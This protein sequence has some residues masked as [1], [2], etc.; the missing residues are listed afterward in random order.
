MVSPQYLYGAAVPTGI[1]AGVVMRHGA[2]YVRLGKRL[3]RV[4]DPAFWE[5]VM[6]SDEHRRRELCSIAAR[7][8]P[9]SAYLNDVEWRSDV[10]ALDVM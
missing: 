1:P 5:F 6:R 9:A 3:V 7:V 4:S 2:A 8:D 10:G